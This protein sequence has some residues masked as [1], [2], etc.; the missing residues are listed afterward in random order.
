[1]GDCTELDENL[2]QVSRVNVDFS[3]FFG[4]LKVYYGKMMKGREMEN[5]LMFPVL[6]WINLNGKGKFGPKIYLCN[7]ATS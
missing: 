2:D 5:G 7:K 4:F 3:L 6:G 1:M